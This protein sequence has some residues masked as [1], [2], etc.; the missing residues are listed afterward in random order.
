MGRRSH[1]GAIIRAGEYQTVTIRSL[2]W[3]WA[4]AL[5]F[6]GLTAGATSLLYRDVPG[7]TR[8]ADLIV[9]GKVLRQESRWT[10][11]K[12]R[13]VTDV[14]VEVTETLKGNERPRILIRQPGGVVGDIGQ[15]VSAVATFSRGEEVI[16]FLERRPDDSFVVSGMAQGK[17]RIERSSDGRS[18]FAL[19]DPAAG[20]AR[21]VDPMTRQEVHAERRTYALDELRSE[22]RRSIVA[23]V[24]ETPGTIDGPVQ[25][26][27]GVS[28][29]TPEGR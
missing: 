4:L 5:V 13:I 14:E 3:L 28:P 2:K 25:K 22:I 17:Y 15:K 20:D 16:V 9:R 18:V 29:A 8:D 24:E 1:N 7:L 10:G 11:D 27:P 21:I 19:P 26:Q 6:C 12:R 23:P